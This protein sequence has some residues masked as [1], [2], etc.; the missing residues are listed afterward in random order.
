MS[1]VKTLAGQCGIDPLDCLRRNI[2]KLADRQAR[3]TLTGN[4]DER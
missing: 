2:A 1:F 4:G 3:G